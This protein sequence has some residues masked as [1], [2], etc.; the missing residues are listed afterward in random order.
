MSFVADIAKPDLF[1]FIKPGPCQGA[2]LLSFIRVGFAAVEF[3]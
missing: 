1:D 3:Q 2:G